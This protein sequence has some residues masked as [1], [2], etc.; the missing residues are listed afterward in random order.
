MPSETAIEKGTVASVKISVLRI[1]VHHTG[2][3]N[4]VT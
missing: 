3:R 2:S 4:S 1:A